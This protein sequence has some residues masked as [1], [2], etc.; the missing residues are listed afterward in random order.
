MDGCEIYKEHEFFILILQWEG[1]LG[2]TM[3]RFFCV[4]PVFIATNKDLLKVER[5]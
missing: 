2:D 4:N 1:G 5:E 3:G